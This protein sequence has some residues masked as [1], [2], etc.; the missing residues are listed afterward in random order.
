MRLHRVSGYALLAVIFGH[1]LAVR[2]PSLALGFFPGFAGVSFS[3]WWMPAL[4]YPYYLLFGASALYHGV[5]GTL[6]ALH[7]L[8][9][10]RSTSIPGGRLGLWLPVGVG[11]AL[12]VL[13]L[14]ALGGRLFPIADPRDNRYAEMWE[15]RFGVELGPQ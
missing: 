8:G 15:E 3:L 12:V 6:L 9:L 13:A 11:S 5:N 14:L 4:F 10:R 1:V 2:G 7:T